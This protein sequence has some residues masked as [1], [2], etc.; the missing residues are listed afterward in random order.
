MTNYQDLFRATVYLNNT[1]IYLLEQG[2]G[3]LAIST[4]TDAVALSKHFPS[5]SSQSD[6]DISESFIHDL[7][8][9]PLRRASQRRALTS[10][11]CCEGCH[12]RSK[13]ANDSQ[14]TCRA[15]FHTRVRVHSDDVE[16][17]VRSTG[18]GGILQ[19]E[20]QTDSF[21]HMLRIESLVTEDTSPEELASW[22]AIVV[23]NCGVAYQYVATL[24]STGPVHSVKLQA[25]ALHLFHLGFSI[26]HNNSPGLFDDTLDWISSSARTT[27]ITFLILE[28]T[29]Q[30]SIRNNAPRDS[31]IHHDA[32]LQQMRIQLNE[33]VF[34][35]NRCCHEQSRVVAAAA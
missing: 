26:I 32:L 22:C 33:V 21:L 1:G 7:I 18:A 28:R 14:H 34:T 2:R 15:L 35:L 17:L 30:Q 13:A 25:G 27:W 10:V 9:H 20:A 6:S 3:E 8:E 29:V 4:F 31:F 19:N 24:P 23:Y 11:V 5:S 16:Y 12:G